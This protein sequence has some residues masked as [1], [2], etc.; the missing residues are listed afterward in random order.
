MKLDLYQV[1]AFADQLFSGNPAA[2]VP[3]EQWLPDTTM[4]QIAGENNLS[5]TA[6]IVPKGDDF[7]LRWF[8]PNKEVDLCGHA[9]LATAYVLFEQLNHGESKLQFH[10]KSGILTV[11]RDGD[12]LVMEFPADELTEIEITDVLNRSVNGLNI[13]AAFRGKDDVLVIIDS[14]QELQALHPDLTAIAQI[15]AR[16][17]IVSAPG[18]E[19]DFVSRC[20]YPRFGIAEDPVTGSAHTTMTPYWAERIDKSTLTARQIS[21]RSGAVTCTLKGSRVLLKG[22]GV[23]YM[24]GEIQLPAT[25]C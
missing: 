8:T 2:V 21:K 5:E 11:E 4:Q 12:F 14:E 25:L 13:Q 16:G 22:Q 17:L 15:E 20:F 7:E 19:V 9:T 18:E 1:D 3:L 10:T 24:K 6:F 23:F